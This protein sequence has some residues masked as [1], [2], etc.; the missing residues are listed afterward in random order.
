[1]NAIP[2]DIADLIWNYDGGQEVASKPVIFSVLR[3]GTWDQIK[4][5]FS[6]YGRGRVKA[7]IEQDFFGDRS[8][9]VSVRAFWGNVFWPDNP[10]PELAEPMERWRPTRSK[11]M[12][13][14]AAVRERLGAALKVS[15]LSQSSFAALLGT[16][17]PRLS[18]YL[19]GKVTPSAALLLRAERL[20]RSLAPE[21][22]VLE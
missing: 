18:S 17:Q 22:Q 8:L 3:L 12:D 9:P 14:M 16:S 21:R 6:F 1:M 4:W 20:G 2:A 13:E 11:K 15:G 5:M 7:V 19:S 10:P